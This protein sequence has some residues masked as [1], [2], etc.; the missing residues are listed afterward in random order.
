MI[1]GAVYRLTNG[2]VLR[3]C[4]VVEEEEVVLKEG[5][6]VIFSASPIHGN[7]HVSLQYLEL[8]PGDID[9]RSIDEVRAAKNAEINAAR[10]AANQSTFTFSGKAIACDQLSRS[11]IDGVNGIVTLTQALPPGFPMAWKAV[12]NTYVA[13]PS[14]SVWRDFYGAMVSQGLAN[15]VRAQALKV[16][17]SQAET[18]AD[19]EAIK[20]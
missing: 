17:V 16:A 1:Y 9:E 7:V 2:K 5:E 10:L 8:V 11:D 3:V 20:W 12:D 19:V 4:A 18:A 15:F 14:V 13:I 6:G